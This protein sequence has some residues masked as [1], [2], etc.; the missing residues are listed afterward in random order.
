[1]ARTLLPIIRCVTLGVNSLL[2]FA[3]ISLRFYS[4]HSD[5]QYHQSVV[6]WLVEIHVQIRDIRRLDGDGDDP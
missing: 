5:M 6:C 1:M 4:D 3:L 2:T